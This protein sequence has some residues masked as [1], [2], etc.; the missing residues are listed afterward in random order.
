MKNCRCD[1][2][3]GCLQKYIGAELDKNNLEFKCPNWQ[4]KGDCAKTIAAKD[5]NRLM[6]AA[7]V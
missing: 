1:F 6:T 4:K 5:Q 7:M 2:H 3:V